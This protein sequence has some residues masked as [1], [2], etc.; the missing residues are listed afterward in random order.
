MTS[1]VR[2]TTFF[3]F[4]A[5]SNADAKTTSDIQVSLSPIGH[6]GYGVCGRILL[7]H[8]NQLVGKKKYVIRAVANFDIHSLANV[9]LGSMT[10]VTLNKS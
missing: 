3:I 4:M 10:E 5:V 6:S 9:F 8:L 7:E 2:K 1:P